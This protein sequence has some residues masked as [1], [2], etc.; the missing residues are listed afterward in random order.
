MINFAQFGSRKIFRPA[1]E[2]EAWIRT[3]AE[4]HLRSR[5]QPGEY[6]GRDRA[7]EVIKHQ[8]QFYER[9]LNNALPS[10]LER[11]SV[12]FL[13]SQFDEASELLHGN[14]ILDL[15]EREKWRRIEPFFKRGI[16][17][18]VERIC[19]MTANSWTPTEPRQS[20]LAINVAMVCAEVLSHM[21][22]ESD[23]VFSIFPEHGTAS[24][25]PPGQV[26]HCNIHVTGRHSEYAERF[27]ARLRRDRQ[28]R[29]KRVAWPPFAHHT[30]THQRYLDS[31]FQTEFGM[32]YGHF[33]HVITQTIT[34]SHPS[35]EPN[36]FE[37]LFISRNR[38]VAGLVEVS[39][40]TQSAIERALDGFTIRSENLEQEQR[41]ITKPKQTHRAFRRGFFLMPHEDGPHL[42]FSRA[43]ARENLINMC[44]AVAFQKLPPE[45]TTEATKRAL[46]DLSRAAGRWFEQVLTD[47]LHEIGIQGSGVT[48]R[49]GSGSPALEIPPDVG[50]IDFLGFHKG[51]NLIVVIEAKMVSGALEPATWRDELHD[52]LGEKKYADRFRRKIRWVEKNRQEI[53]RAL[54]VDSNSRVVAALVTYYPSIVAEFIHDFPCVS[55]AEL[56]LDFEKVRGWP[57]PPPALAS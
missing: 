16:K 36:A 7:N 9:L 5:F 6:Q 38:L 39:G 1:P 54:G 30:E 18:L 55:L 10:L 3:G 27:S 52:F 50:Q 48:R 56:I 32:T 24:V 34:N 33:I 22:Q 47:R 53:T 28:H 25:L 8:F 45:W 51:G 23:L 41:V 43:M 35:L 17:Y 4:K 13:L 29:D 49:L 40:Q 37:T 26:V 46:S 14:G 57:Y 42:C 12:E 15:A 21:A 2:V 19:L 11:G 44:G 20:M 31:V